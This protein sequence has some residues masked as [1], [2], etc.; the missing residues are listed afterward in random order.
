[1]AHDG[2]MEEEKKCTRLLIKVY[3]TMYEVCYD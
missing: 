1:M 3:N 2:K